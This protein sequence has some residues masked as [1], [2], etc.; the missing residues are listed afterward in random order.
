MV[1]KADRDIVDRRLEETL[2][3]FEPTTRQEEAAEGQPGRTPKSRRWDR[4]NPTFAF[5]IL[6]EDNERIGEWASKLGATRDEL[7][8]GLMGA[9]LEALEQG[10]LD[11]AFE[12]ETAVKQVPV[13]TPSG[14]MTTRRITTTNS[15]VKWT[16]KSGGQT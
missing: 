3:L 7:A 11:L 15:N 1:K 2:D 14:G 12:R 5:R 16:W 8:R 10:R 6:P 4:D 13:R 9:A